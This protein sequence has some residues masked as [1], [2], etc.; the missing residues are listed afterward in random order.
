[1]LIMVMKILAAP[2]NWT[3]SYSH[4]TKKKSQAFLICLAKDLNA[5]QGN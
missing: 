4:E 5:K 1:M 3:E 2:E